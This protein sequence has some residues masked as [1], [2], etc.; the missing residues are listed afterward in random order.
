MAEQPAVLRRLIESPPPSLQEVAA[1]LRRAPPRAVV[2]AARGSS[3]HAAVYGRYLFEV[4]N[5]ALTSLAA[6]AAFTVYGSGP[7]LRD[8]LVIGVSQSG[9]GEDVRRVVEEARAHGAMT[10]AIVNDPRSPLA[11]AAQYVFDC[12]A[13]PE[14]AVP[15]TK[16]VT[17]QMLLLAQLSA[18]WR[19]GDPDPASLEELPDAVAQALSLRDEAQSLA[20][21]LGHVEDVFALGRGFA[22]PVALEVALKLKE[23]AQVHAAAWSSADFRHGPIAL[24]SPRN[25]VLALDAGGLST[26]HALDSAREVE[27]RGGEAYLLRA[28]RFERFRD[29]PALALRCDLAEHHA[30]IALL[31][32]GQLLA[33]EVAKARGVDPSNPPG[34]KKVTSTR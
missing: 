3:D 32:L 11:Q 16:T 24:V 31:V 7:E 23:M 27:R 29:S 19:G 26:D 20:A 15:A 4:H 5:R 8:A 25:R 34:L 10:V 6:P 18:A 12:G 2:L 22:Y 21:H 13:G 14:L 17:A 9:R 30:A 33:L 28:G 1:R